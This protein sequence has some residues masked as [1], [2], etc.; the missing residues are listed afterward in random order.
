LKTCQRE[1]V[2]LSLPNSEVKHAPTNG[3]SPATAHWYDASTPI[4]SSSVPALFVS[5]FV[6]TLITTTTPL[7]LL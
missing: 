6:A 4:L 3:R 2:K 7:A 5:S 1:W